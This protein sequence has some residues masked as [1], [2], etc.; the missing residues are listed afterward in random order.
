MLDTLVERPH[1]R[2]QL[3]RRIEERFTE[4]KAVMAL[5]LSGFSLATLKRGIVASLLM[6][7]QMR[8]LARP[9]I[10]DRDGV[11]VKAPADNLF[12]LFPRAHDA[13]AAARHITRSLDAANAALPDGLELYVS[14]GIGYGP[15]LVLGDEDMWG[16]EV[17]LAAK[18]GEDIADR[19]EI[20]LTPAARAELGDEQGLIE[21]CCEVSG[22]ELTYYAVRF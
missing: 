20:L 7:H 13:L 14:V 4:R 2:E 22:L 6:S 15:L 8:V 19:G 17:N 11:V 21:R 3:E 9:A 12:C 1:E 5:D 10:E 18:L 16:G